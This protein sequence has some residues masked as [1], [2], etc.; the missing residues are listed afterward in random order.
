M[1][2]EGPT[3]GGKKGKGESLGHRVRRGEERGG[4]Q[5]HTRLSVG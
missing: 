1:G 4:E 2:R 5:D 3:E